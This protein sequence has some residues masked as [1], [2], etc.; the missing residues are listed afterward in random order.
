MEKSLGE[1]TN[2]PV[3]VIL[4]AVRFDGIYESTSFNTAKSLAKYTPVYYVENPYTFKDLYKERSQHHLKRRWKYFFKKK[5]TIWTDNPFLQVVVVRPLLSIHFLPEGKLY[6]SLLRMNERIIAKR[7]RSIMDRDGIDD[8]IFINS[9][10]FHYPHVG[11]LLS[12]KLT[13]YQCV[14]PLIMEFDRKHGVYSEKELLQKSDMVICTS[15]ALYL[16]KSTI[17]PATYFVPNAADIDH[18]SKAMD[19]SLPVL[20]ALKAFQKPIVGYVGNIE[21]RLDYELLYQLVRDNPQYSFVF[22]GPVSMELVPDWI[23]RQPNL[24]LIGRVDYKD[25]PSLLKGFDICFIPFKKDE[26]SATIFPLKLFEYLGSGKP[27]ISTSFNPDLKD[28]T[29]DTVIYCDDAESFS[30][31][32]KNALLDNSEARIDTRIAIAKRNTWDTRA[33]Q[34]LGL[35]SSASQKN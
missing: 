18:S 13:V 21:R 32:I 7:I 22:A 35:I 14:D 30:K 28:F 26:V 25:L 24:H 4:G 5:K 19:K 17:N 9:F 6:R 16:E 12:P 29:D 34:W 8:Y 3:I 20:P 15:Q 10:N 31:A 23:F 27:V 1:N 33:K 2:I 11:Q